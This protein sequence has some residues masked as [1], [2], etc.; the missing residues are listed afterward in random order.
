MT[1]TRS[2]FHANCLICGQMRVVVYV[3]GCDPIAVCTS[4][5]FYQPALRNLTVPN[6]QKRFWNDNDS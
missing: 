3:M 4:C 5:D 2:Y 1:P 6:L